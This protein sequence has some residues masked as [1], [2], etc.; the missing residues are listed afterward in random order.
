[1]SQDVVGTE[2]RGPQWPHGSMS[3]APK[4]AI[5]KALEWPTPGTST[6][7]W[8]GTVVPLKG[9]VTW[10]RPGAAEPHRDGRGPVSFSCGT[11]RLS[12]CRSRR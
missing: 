10:G 1:M 6:K 8:P 3:R 2:G 9:L 11:G 12:A 4:A 7:L 5:C